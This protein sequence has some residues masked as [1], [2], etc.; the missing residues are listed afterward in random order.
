M[1][2]SRVEEAVSGF[3]AAA[4]ARPEDHRARYARA[5]AY[6]RLGRYAE[7]ADDL[8]AVLALFPEDAELYEER[9]AC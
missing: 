6:K 8:T 7:R 5:Q 4:R 2:P 3:T 9:A 1:R